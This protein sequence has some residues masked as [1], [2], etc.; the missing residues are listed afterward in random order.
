SKEDIVKQLQ[1]KEKF[2]MRTAVHDGLICSAVF[3]GGLCMIANAFYEGINET[4]EFQ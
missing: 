4:V 2:D 3:I 1:L